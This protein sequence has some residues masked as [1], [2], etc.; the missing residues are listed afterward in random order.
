MATEKALPEESKHTQCIICGG[1]QWA[2]LRQGRDWLRP[3]DEVK[4]KLSRCI[5]CGHVMQTPPPSNAEL[6]EAYSEDYVHYRPAWEEPGWPFWKI[7]RELTTRRRIARLKDYGRGRKLLEIGSGAG[8]FLYAAHQA[9]WEVRAVEYNE[10]SAEALREGLGLDVRTGELRP[11]L[12]NEGEFDVVALWNVLEHVPDPLDTLLTATSYLKPGGSLFLQFPT[13]DATE[14]EKWFGEYWI[15]LD[16]PRH[17][18]FFAR[19]SLSMLC[20]KAGLELTAFKTPALD[21]AWCYFASSCA[22][23]LHARNR[24][25]WLL[26]AITAGSRGVL[27]LPK[28]ALRAWQG[29]GTEAFAIAVKKQ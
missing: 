2:F 9:G 13:H 16:L 12:W 3:D 24:P 19:D 27:A 22:Y 1:E 11:G 5:S 15:L 20:S 28:M 8:D 26:R 18:N 23:I 4:F 7:L 17:L 25:Q 14:H 21:A 10:K 29:H 6:R